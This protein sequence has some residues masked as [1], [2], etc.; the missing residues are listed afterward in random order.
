MAL[1]VTADGPALK[2]ATNVLL[3]AG[4][5]SRHR[6]EPG[7]LRRDLP[8]H[9]RPRAVAHRHRARG[10]S[11]PE[12]AGDGRRR[13]HADQPA[14]RGREGGHLS[15]L[16]RHRRAT[17]RRR[18]EQDDR[19]RRRLGA[20][21]VRSRPRRSSS[22]SRR[23][24]RQSPTSIARPCPARSPSSTSGRRRRRRRTPTRRRSFEWIGRAAISGCRATSC[25]STARSPT[26]IPHGV[27][28]AWHTT[29]RLPALEDRPIV[30]EFNEERIVARPWPAKEGHMT[31]LE[32]TG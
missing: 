7:R 9:H 10:G 14:G 31:I 15:R 25:C 6:F 4:R 23:P 3:G 26:D 18:A 11:R 5:P 27:P 2:G 32:L 12:R 30:G 29:L 17:R 19:R 8:L 16:R 22:W 1:N 20:G 28:V 24:A 13:R 21:D